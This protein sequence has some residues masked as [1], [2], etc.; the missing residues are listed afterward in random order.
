MFVGETALVSLAVYGEVLLMPQF[1]LLDHGHDDVEPTFLIDS[2]LNETV[3]ITKV[4]ALMNDVF[5]AVC[6]SP[7][8]V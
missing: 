4:A 8:C 7:S 2:A 6:A 5:Q 3:A 1:E